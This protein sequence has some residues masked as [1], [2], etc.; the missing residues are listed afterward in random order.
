MQTQESQTRP[1][2]DVGP[3]RERIDE[4]VFQFFYN[5]AYY[6]GPIE[7]NSYGALRGDGA[8]SSLV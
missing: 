7:V 4:Q 1:P 6:F 5:D 3:T 8:A 2:T